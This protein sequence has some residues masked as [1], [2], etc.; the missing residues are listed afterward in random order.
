MSLRVLALTF[1]GRETASTYYRVAQYVEILRANHGIE[2]VMHRADDFSRAPELRDFDRVFV[3][4][5]LLRGS[6]R[7]AVMAAGRPV[8]YDIDDAIWHPHGRRHSWFTRW[9]T[10]QRLAAIA[11]G[12][13]L[14]LASNEYLAAGLRRFTDRVRILPMAL[15]ESIWT[16]RKAATA[17]S[18]I[19]LGWA[20]APGNLR[21]LEALEP[22]LERVLAE[23]PAARV[24]VFSGARPNFRRIDFDYLPYESG[25]EAD[26]VRRF[27]IGLLPLPRDPFASGKSPIKALQYMASG[28]PAIADAA[29]GAAEIF[30]GGGALLAREPGDWSMH[31]RALLSSAAERA[32]VGQLARARFV[33]N[34]T[35][36]ENARKLAGFLADPSVS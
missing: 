33:A 30:A 17:G 14:C 36:T 34:H 2:L 27:D 21:Y 35:R 31:L 9:R 26:V 29:E 6:E 12:A 4:K 3:Q 18:A 13:S 10:D 22:D 8:L 32:A 15:D 7:R 28:V 19:R 23:F 11:R 16:P 1:G 5:K 24:A 20:G 25:R